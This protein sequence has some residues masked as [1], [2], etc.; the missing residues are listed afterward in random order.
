MNRYFES[1]KEL[2]FLFSSKNQEHP[3]YRNLNALLL[4]E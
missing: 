1:F 3:S 2:E 4:Q